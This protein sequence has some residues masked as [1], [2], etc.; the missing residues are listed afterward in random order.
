VN[1]KAIIT[2]EGWTAVNLTTTWLLAA[3]VHTPMPVSVQ[4]WP[5]PDKTALDTLY[6]AKA[7]FW[8][9]VIAGFIAAIGTAFA[10]VDYRLNIRQF[11]KA[12]LGVSLCGAGRDARPLPTSIRGD[13]T[14]ITFSLLLQLNNDGDRA[15]QQSYVTVWIPKTL[16]WAALSPPWTY[17]GEYPDP[18]LSEQFRRAEAFVAEP[19]FVDHPKFL[20]PM[21]LSSDIGPQEFTIR[22]QVNDEAGKTPSGLPAI[23][24]TGIG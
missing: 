18:G 7:A 9:T 5:P 13:G 17:G 24:Y 23:I 2:I 15:A 22:W 4:N 16:D 12:K 21:Y 3:A 8:A 20:P 6:Y 19:V 10:Y 1:L 11:R 14:H